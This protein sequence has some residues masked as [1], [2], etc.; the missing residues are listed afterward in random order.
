MPNC[1]EKSKSKTIEFSGQGRRVVEGCF[2]GGSMTSDAGSFKALRTAA[3]FAPAAIAASTSSTT[4]RSRAV[5]ERFLSPVASAR[6]TSATLSFVMCLPFRVVGI[7]GF[8]DVA[9]FLQC[10]CSIARVADSRYSV[11]V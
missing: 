8:R 9:V 5:S 4:S 2:A 10:M 3:R 11:S 1:T 6:S 7:A